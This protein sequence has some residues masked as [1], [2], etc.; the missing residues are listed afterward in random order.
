MYACLVLCVCAIHA[1]LN[2]HTPRGWDFIEGRVVVVV[3]WRGDQIRVG[4]R[5]VHDDAV[6]EKVVNVETLRDVVLLEV[7]VVEVEA[8]GLVL[9]AVEPCGA[10]TGGANTRT[11]DR[12]R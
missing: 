5:V 4:R 2:E 10:D 3:E 7:E 6:V 9:A 1:T 8:A 11:A 12:I